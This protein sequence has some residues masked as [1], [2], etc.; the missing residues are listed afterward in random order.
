MDDVQ[1][2][3]SELQSASSSLQTATTELLM[4]NANLF[5][6]DTGVENPAGRASLRLEFHRRLTALHDLGLQLVE[7]ASS[8]SASLTAIA[9]RY[10]DLDVELTGQEQR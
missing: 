5:G 6:E 9:D 4:E 1:V 2:F 10:S 8:V 3:Y 7:D